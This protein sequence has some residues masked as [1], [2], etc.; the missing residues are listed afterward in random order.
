MALLWD[1]RPRIW[2]TLRDIHMKYV[3]DAVRALEKSESFRSAR[4]RLR[5]RRR[6]PPPSP[7]GA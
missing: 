4:D 3:P 1:T 6:R 2:E 7:S 5:R